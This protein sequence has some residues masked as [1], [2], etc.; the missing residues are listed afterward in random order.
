[1]GRIL[2]ACEF[3]GTVRRAFAA[4]GLAGM[5]HG[6]V[7]CC[8]PKTGATSTSSVTPAQSWMMAGI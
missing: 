6:R 8:R 2:V 7:I 4:R 3:S 1:M 5:M